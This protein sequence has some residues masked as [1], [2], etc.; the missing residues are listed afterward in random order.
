MRVRSEVDWW[1]YAVIVSIPIVAITPALFSPSEND[2]ILLG[3]IT[4]TAMALPVWLLATY[5]E[6][7]ET[8]LKITSGPFKWLIPY[9]DIHSI[10][11]SK[12]ILS[13]PALSLDRLR[14]SYGVSKFVLI[15]PRQRDKFVSALNSRI[16]E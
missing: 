14:I 2:A 13:S 5:Y 4:V 6:L 8:Q 1:Y 9:T 12:S 7:E 15:S 11:E 16:G 3:L 10:E